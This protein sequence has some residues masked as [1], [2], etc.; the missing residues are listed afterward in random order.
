[1]Q[2]QYNCRATHQENGCR[3]LFIRNQKIPCILLASLQGFRHSQH[4]LFIVSGSN[5]SS[6]SISTKQTSKR[7]ITH[8]V[9]RAFFFILTYFAYGTGRV[10][11]ET[12]YTS[13]S[14]RNCPYTY[15]YII[16]FTKKHQFYSREKKTFTILKIK[17]NTHKN[18]EPHIIQDATFSF[19]DNSSSN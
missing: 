16:I 10:T 5:S 7:A 4:G 9:K 11:S 14:E 1:M 2:M 6:I 15:L 12:Q 3:H 17:K 8:I 13:L 18:V 19:I